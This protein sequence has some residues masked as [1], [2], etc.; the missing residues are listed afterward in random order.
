MLR[1][2]CGRRAELGGRH[3]ETLAEALA[4]IGVTGETT[5]FGYL[6]DIHI[7]LTGHEEG[8]ILQTQLL[9]IVG[10][11]G[12][13][14]TLGEGVTHTLLRQLEAVHDGLAVHIRV[15]EQAFAHDD[16]VDMLE[17]LL[18]GQRIQICYVAGGDRLLKLQLLN[19]K[20]L[21][22]QDVS[23]YSPHKIQ[24]RDFYLQ[25]RL[26]IKI[27]A[28]HLSLLQRPHILTW[29]KTSPFGLKNII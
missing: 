22:C 20:E 10:D 17:Q 7:R 6:G 4:E 14:A 23:A 15:E 16:I 13:L 24:G 28:S 9:Q 8:G 3:A 18:I 25:A 1:F 27:S 29:A 12:I 19:Q 2:L 5:D 26:Q 11:L 21:P